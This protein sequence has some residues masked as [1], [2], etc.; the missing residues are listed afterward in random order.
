MALYT[1][2]LGFVESMVYMSPGPLYHTAPLMACLAVHRLGGT[3]VVMDRFDAEE[4]LRA[5]ERYHVTHG[6]WVPTMFVRMLKLDDAVRERYDISSLKLALHAAAPCP[7][8][9]KRR[10]IEWW[11]PVLL[12]F[13]SGTEGGGMTSITTEEWLR[14]P[15]S[16]GRAVEGS[17]VHVTGEDGRELP[18]GE[19]GLVWFSGHPPA[20]FHN[21]PA[22]TA[23]SRN[24]RGWSTL[25]D[26]G[27]L[28]SDGYLYLT[29]RASH[30]IVS[31][32]VNISPAE[33][34]DVLIMHPAV[35]DVAVIGVPDADRGEQVK[36]IVQLA[37]DAAPSDATADL[38]LQLCRRHLAPF[39]VPRSVDFVAQLPRT[40][41]GKLMKRRLKDRYW[42]GHA[43]RVI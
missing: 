17:S 15:G 29:D 22:R 36:A 9:V 27:Y 26:L 14:H 13:Y 34:E 18:P 19:A 33:I 8:E 16:V 20:E 25:G 42:D 37:P 23:A 35:A 7:I 30:M 24:E 12:E 21:D 39:K 41:A 28:D 1:G 4:C 40:P 11:G 3:A 38:L 31:A 5:I 2:P 10:M 32:G 6:Q 43:T